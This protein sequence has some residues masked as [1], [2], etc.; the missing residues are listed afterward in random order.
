LS[1]LVRLIILAPILAPPWLRFDGYCIFNNGN[2][3]NF[4]LERFSGCLDTEREDIKPYLD[5]GWTV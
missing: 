2:S 3:G 1:D 4:L 5:V